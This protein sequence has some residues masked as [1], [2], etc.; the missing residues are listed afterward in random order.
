[1]S[2]LA[3]EPATVQGG[4]IDQIEVRDEVGAALARLSPGEREVVSLRFG[5]DL[6]LD[7]IARVSHERVSTVRGRLYRGLEKLRTEFDRTE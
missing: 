4:G 5:A 6:S 3:S 1:V 2:R 7:D